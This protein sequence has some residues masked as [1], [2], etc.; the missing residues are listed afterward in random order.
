MTETERLLVKAIRAN[1]DDDL[2]RLVYADWLE[3]DAEPRQPERAA[4]IRYAIRLRESGET[5]HP[6]NYA[7][8]LNLVLEGKRYV[9]EIAPLIEGVGWCT[10]YGLVSSASALGSAWQ[11]H[12][13]AITERHPLERVTLTSQ[14]DPTWL[15]K[16]L[17]K[18]DGG[19]E[20]E[21]KIGD[22]YVAYES[23]RN[24]GYRRYLT[25]LLSANW[26][27]IAF[28][29]SPTV[30]ETRGILDAAYDAGRRVGEAIDRRVLDSLLRPDEV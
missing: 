11:S 7:A 5:I 20:L 12:A 1:P 2:P 30:G 23:V 24:E 22:R 19:A 16:R 15:R 29:I 18:M 26:P 17:R 28:T 4:W 25:A 3:G 14:P 27:G 9:I 8:S 13:D 21:E 10:R 6:P